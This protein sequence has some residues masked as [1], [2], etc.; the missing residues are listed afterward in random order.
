MAEDKA[1]D[2]ALKRRLM[3]V[4]IERLR[5]QEAQMLDKSDEF[6]KKAAMVRGEAEEIV[7]ALAAFDQSAGGCP[8]RVDGPCKS[9]SVD[10][11]VCLYCLKEV[12]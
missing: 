9:S 6:R 12:A 5:K 11:R 2:R 1:V 7:R 4:D 8:G 10:P 3:L